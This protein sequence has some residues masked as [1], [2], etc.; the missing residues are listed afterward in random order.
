[1]TEVAGLGPIEDY[2]LPGD[3]PDVADGERLVGMLTRAC[4]VHQ[5]QL[6]EA[7]QLGRGRP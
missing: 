3:R 2:P 7:L 4:I 6:R 1:M 5:W